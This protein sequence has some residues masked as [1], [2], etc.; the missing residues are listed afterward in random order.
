[1]SDSLEQLTDQ[2]ISNMPGLEGLPRR[3]GELVFHDDWERRVFALAVSLCEQGQ[4]Q[5]DEFRDHLIAAI[6]A[7]GETPEN[8]KPGAPGYFEHWLESFE[9]ILEEKGLLSVDYSLTQSD[10]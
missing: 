8:P 3:N 6:A 1:M 2:A 9:K 10:D 4:Y 5:W 7:A